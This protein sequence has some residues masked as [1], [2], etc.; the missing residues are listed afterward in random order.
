MLLDADNP[1][2]VT[3]IAAQPLLAPSEPYETDGFVPNV[4]FP[5]G[6]VEV[7]EQIHVYYGAADES[8]AVAQTT[9]EQLWTAFDS[10]EERT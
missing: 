6:F 7:G 5:G 9:W 8:T 4:V 10:P 3:Q 1:A 2:R